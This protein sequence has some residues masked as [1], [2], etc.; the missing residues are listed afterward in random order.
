M[1]AYSTIKPLLRGSTHLERCLGTC[2]AQS[3]YCVSE[4]SYKSQNLGGRKSLFGEVWVLVAQSRLTLC[5]PMDCRPPGSSAHG[6]LQ[7]R[8]LEWVALPFSSGFSQPRDQ[9]RVF[10]I[11]GRFFTVW[12]TTGF[13]GGRSG[14][15]VFPSLSELSTVC[16]DPHSQRLWYSQYFS[17]TLLLFQWSSGCWQFDLWFLWFF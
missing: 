3:N 5:D 8:T 9:T 12:A 7:A 16:C 4:Q 2:I 17:G 6:I 13:S 15:L 14:G 11:A 1:N 10:H